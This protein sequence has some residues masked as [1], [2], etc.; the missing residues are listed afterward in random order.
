MTGVPLARLWFGVGGV[1]GMVAVAGSALVAHA[2]PEAMDSARRGMVASVPTMLGWHALALLGTG[3]W[4]E[5]HPCLR[6]HLA[7]AAFTV[8]SLLFAGG[9]LS[10]ALGD[11]AYGRAAPTGGVLLILGWAALAASSVGRPPAR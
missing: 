3:L 11:G 9:V 7:G 6:V 10:L 5:R 2:L 8:G 1:F 4:A